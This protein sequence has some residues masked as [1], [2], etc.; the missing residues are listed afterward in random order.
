MTKS[1]QPLKEFGRPSRN[2]LLQGTGREITAVNRGSE[3][4]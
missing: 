3:G 1:E 4:Q 2:D